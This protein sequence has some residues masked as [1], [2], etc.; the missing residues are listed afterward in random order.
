VDSP[1][2]A[3]RRGLCSPERPAVMTSTAARGPEAKQREDGKKIGKSAAD[4]YLSAGAEENKD[5]LH[6]LWVDSF[7]V[8]KISRLPGEA[9]G[10]L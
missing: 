9:Q 7:C 2:R 4:K 8:R 5:R 3:A 10:G 6:A 1:G